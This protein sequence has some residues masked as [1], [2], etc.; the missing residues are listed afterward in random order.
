M[1]LQQLNLLF[2]GTILMD[3]HISSDYTK[4]FASDLMSDVLRYRMENTVL[5]T[6]L[7]TIQ[8]LRTAEMSNI[9]CIIFARGKRVTPDMLALA[10]EHHITIIESELTLFELSGRL[11]QGGLK[12]VCQ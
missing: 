6:G 7:C 11:Y 3:G 5:I 10:K 2:N 4:A 9:T 1:N 8:V 12:P